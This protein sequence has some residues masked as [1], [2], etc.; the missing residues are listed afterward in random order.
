[1][2]VDLCKTPLIMCYKYNQMFC[3]EKINLNTLK[4]DILS[5]NFREGSF[6]YITTDAFLTRFHRQKRK[7][8]VEQWH[9]LLKPGGKIATTIRIE[10][11]PGKLVTTD[12]DIDRYMQKAKNGLTRSGILSAYMKDKILRSAEMYAKNITSYPLNDEDEIRDLFNKFDDVK[13]KYNDVDGEIND[14]TR[15][16]QVIARKRI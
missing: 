15:Y 2:I 5:T 4:Q 14:S 7:Q 1:M 11:T 8:V 9:A 12:E 16:A 13:V 3:G 6:N 10:N